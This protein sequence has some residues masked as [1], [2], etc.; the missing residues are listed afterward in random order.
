[1]EIFFLTLLIVI[2]GIFIS[3]LWKA[4]KTNN[5]LVMECDEEEI[6]EYG[7]FLQE[8]NPELYEF[9]G[10]GEVNSSSEFSDVS[11]PAFGDMEL[12]EFEIVQS[13]DEK[14]KINQ[15]QILNEQVQQFHTER[16]KLQEEIQLLYEEMQDL[17]DEL[18]EK[19]KKQK[20]IS[21]CKKD[22]NKLKELQ[23][24]IYDCKEKEKRAQT[25]LQKAQEDL[26]KAQED[27]AKAQEDLA[28]VLDFQ[29]QK[30]EWLEDEMQ[31]NRI[32]NDK[33]AQLQEV[34]QHYDECQLHLRNLKA[35]LEAGENELR[36]QQ[37]YLFEIQEQNN[38][39]IEEI[40]Q[41]Q[42]KNSELTEQNYEKN[43]ILNQLKANSIDTQNESL[44]NKIVD[45][46]LKIT[47][48]QK[49]YELQNESLENKIVNYKLENTRLQ[50][51]YQLQ[52]ESLENKIVNYKSQ[53]KKL[54]DNNERLKYEFAE[55]KDEFEKQNQ[56][57][58]KGSDELED[59]EKEIENIHSNLSNLQNRLFNVTDD[60]LKEIFKISGKKKKTSLF[61]GIFNIFQTQTNSEPDEKEDKLVDINSDLYNIFHKFLTK[62]AELESKN[63]EI[64]KQNKANAE[65]TTTLKSE[66]ET[67]IAE[68][69]QINAKLK[70][71]KSENEAK[72]KT[73]AEKDKTLKSENETKIAEIA[74]INAKLIQYE[75]KIAQINAKLKSLKSENAEKDE[76][77]E[78]KNSELIQYEAK[79]A[80][81]EEINAKLKLEIENIVEVIRSEITTFKA[82]KSENED[83]N[84]EITLLNYKNDAK[85]L[86][87]RK[88][89][90]I[91]KKRN[92]DIQKIIQ[93]HAKN[94]RE[95][96]K[97]L[98]K[99][100]ADNMVKIETIKK[101]ED[102][103]AK[104]KKTDQKQ[105]VFT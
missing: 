74:Q 32:D 45:Y 30:N 7:S 89:N 18:K 57:L 4:K 13:S 11:V 53:N 68:I 1:M 10:M 16:N 61:G 96:N 92:D 103:I 26:A 79:I 35:N 72:D 31:K 67:K 46:E 42:K 54:D 12:S 63:A 15:L 21:D 5:I 41:L 14:R 73:I 59:F 23:F 64:Q 99:V 37:F 33:L 97:V 3:F 36:Q 56:T 34:K 44:E 84:A 48:L 81:I 25:D 28:T 87:N 24:Q 78:E 102:E 65:L 55:L 77:I 43:L 9:L 50:N 71:L 66:N 100:H 86:K 20:P 38:K 19:E 105:P 83:L 51:E 90:D 85:D 95:Y 29:K 88:L 17:T 93:A 40:T 70:S 104:L 8:K 80:E 94:T 2:F 62:I 47:E 49:D 27:L 6:P 82:L 75:G 69:A 22:C 101:L 98:D 58:K 76:T 91:I 52:N 39:L 60:E